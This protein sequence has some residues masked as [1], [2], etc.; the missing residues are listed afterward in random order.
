[1]RARPA[2]QPPP[3]FPEAPLLS[4]TWQLPRPANSSPKHLCICHPSA[5]TARPQ[6]ASITSCLELHSLS[7]DH[8]MRRTLEAAYTCLVAPSDSSLAHP[9]LPLLPTPIYSPAT[10]DLNTW[11]P[12]PVQLPHPPPARPALPTLD[13]DPAARSL[14]STRSPPSGPYLMAGT[15]PACGLPWQPPSMALSK[16]QDHCLFHLGA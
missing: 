10:A 13:H 8:R 4:V 12:L 15:R 14:L 6:P 11:P 2:S 9:S 3:N 7:F 5:F 16:S 1:M